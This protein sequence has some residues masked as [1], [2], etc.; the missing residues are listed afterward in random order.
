MFGP[1]RT[2]IRRTLE[3]GS[4]ISSRTLMPTEVDESRELARAFWDGKSIPCPKHVGVFLRGT[5]VATTY[6]DHIMLDCP[7][8][9]ET[10]AI[11]QRPRQREFNPHQVEGLVVFIQ[12]SDSVRC[13][14]CQSKL[15]IEVRDNIEEGTTQ[16]NFTCV[17]CFSFGSWKGRPEEASIETV[18]ATGGGSVVPSNRP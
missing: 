16:Y 5:F 6:A 2:D 18:T 15:Q 17:R 8:G 7:K 9:R 4:I 13:Y 10:Y 12:R 3:C 14:R 11:P 1:V